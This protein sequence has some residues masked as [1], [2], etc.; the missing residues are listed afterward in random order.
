VT[1]Q[2]RGV[3]KEGSELR[4]DLVVL[5]AFVPDDLAAFVEWAADAE[6]LH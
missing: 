6:P 4:N 2:I 1:R 3:A 5:R